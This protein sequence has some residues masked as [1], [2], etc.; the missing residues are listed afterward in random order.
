M[1]TGLNVRQI[2]PFSVGTDSM[3]SFTLAMTEIK[4]RT[5]TT[6]RSIN[7][8]DDI[9]FT[10]RSE[11]PLRFGQTPT[12]RFDATVLALPHDVSR[13]CFLYLDV[14]LNALA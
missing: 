7:P 4:A 2:T 14:F 5:S 8:A 3:G 6:P 1:R 11:T 9:D 13:G 10:P 12:D